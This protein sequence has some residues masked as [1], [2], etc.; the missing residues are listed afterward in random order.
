[1]CWRS[2]PVFFLGTRST[3][4]L[5]YTPAQ[6][7]VSFIY[8]VGFVCLFILVCMYGVCDVCMYMYKCACPYK[9]VEDVDF[10]TSFRILRDCFCDECLSGPAGPESLESSSLYL[11]YREYRNSHTTMPSLFPGFWRVCTEF[12]MLA[13]HPLSHLPSSVLKYLK[14]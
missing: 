9:C 5:S 2:K 14:C 6:Y 12:L 7:Q 1:M 4:Q 8:L 11:Q 13:L 3:Y 10:G